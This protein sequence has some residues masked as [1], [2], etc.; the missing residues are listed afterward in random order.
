MAS[1][2]VKI[3]EG[4]NAPCAFC[5][6][7]Q[8]K[9][10]Y[11]SK[12][13]DDILTEVRELVRQ[14]IKE[15]ILIAQDT[16]A[17]G[18]DWGKKDALPSLIGHILKAVPHLPWLRL[19]YTHPIHITARLIETMASNGQV[20]HYLD[21]PLQHAHPDV[22]RRMKRPYHIDRIYSLIEH[23]REAMP[24]IALRT[25]FIV[26]YPDETEEEFQALLEF[27]E[28]V[29]LDRVGIF[30]YSQEEGTEAAQLPGQTPK[31]VKEERYRA[32]MAVQQAVSL[33]KNRQFLSKELKVLIE[34]AGDGISVG[35]SYRD[36]PEVDGVVLVGGELPLNRFASVRITEALEYDLIGTS[37]QPEQP[38]ELVLDRW[39]G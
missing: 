29:A 10:P 36:A 24:D 6:I 7:P 35:R 28:Q 23:L 17:Y 9:G 26:G 25:S 5:T 21:L 27:I 32:A 15:I 19:M 31:H 37:C 20:C 38:A 22:L 39:Q 4:C 11:R 34:G 2:Y 3:A 18:H 13:E 1:A 12:S 8:I 30:T 33:R 16:T 14:G